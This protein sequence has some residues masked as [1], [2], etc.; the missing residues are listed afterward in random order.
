MTNYIR[1]INYRRK[2][3]GLPKAKYIYV[4][5][6][7]PDAKI[8]WHHHVIMDGLLDRD[9]CEKLWKLGDRSQSKR[10]EE[11]AYGLVGMAKYITKDKHRQKNE[12][13][14]NCS[15]GLRQFRVR[16]VRS[17]RKGGNGRYVPVS[18]YIDTFVRDKAAREAEIQAWHPEYSLLESQVYYNGVNGMFYI[19]ARL[20]DWRKRDAK[21]RCIHP[22]DS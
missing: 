9:V 22:N 16:K 12:K 7:D 20:R 10:L 8:R 21:G 4:T 6:H 14:W 3:L 19:T 13:R 15:T 18:K 2:K 11:D 5:E 17:K 1:R